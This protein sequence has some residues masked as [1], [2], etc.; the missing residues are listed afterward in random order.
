MNLSKRSKDT[1]DLLIPYMD[2]LIKQKKTKQMKKH[3]DDILKIFYYSMKK[4]HIKYNNMYENNHIYR[5][6]LT[7]SNV[8]KI[9][10]HELL[11]S[12]Y[13]PTKIRDYI[14][15]ETQYVLRY[16]FSIGKKQI[17]VD[18][19]FKNL[20]T[21]SK[22]DKYVK[23]IILALCFINSIQPLT[24]ESPL[25]ILLFPTLHKKALPKNELEILGSNHVNSAVTTNCS[26][27]G[28]S[29]LVY[30]SEEWFKVLIHELMH[31]L[32]MD[33]SFLDTSEHDSKLKKTFFVNSKFNSYE[34][35]C[36]FWATVINT[37]YCSFEML[38]TSDTL[39]DF[40]I[41]FELLINFEK[42]YSIFQMVKVL[43][44]MN[45]KYESLYKSKSS[46][47]LFKEQSNVF[48]YYVLKTILLFNSDAF[49]T[50]CY[51]NNR[52]YFIKFKPTIE[53][54]DV[55]YDFILT[56]YNSS[57]FIHVLCELEKEHVKM[58]SKHVNNNL[59]KFESYA[60][61]TLTMSLCEM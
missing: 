6:L 23:K 47:I 18:I 17:T 40:I 51:F 32:N 25:Q 5:S 28:N 20:Q 42:L 48:S 31:S 43:D 16:K 4:C 49:L 29:I 9:T 34:S 61:K 8:Q 3:M 22:Y 1:I 36:E 33:F 30:R 59:T 52:P 60:L 44:F 37:V 12:G 21:I 10:S 24:C 57:K 26:P 58:K 55:F 35:Y 46:E 15:R 56:H 50:W 13:V 2:I 45:L 7:Y 38:E 27:K 19:G 54:I 41:H 39:E 53:H 11:Y 14:K